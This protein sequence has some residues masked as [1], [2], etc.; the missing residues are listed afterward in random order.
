[1]QMAQKQS[2]IDGIVVCRFC[3]AL[4]FHQNFENVYRT[5]TFPSF[6]NVFRRVRCVEMSL[7]DKARA[8]TGETWKWGNAKRHL[9]DRRMV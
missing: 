8:G 1:M 7:G 3:T 6:I 9:H 2:P 4:H 5:S